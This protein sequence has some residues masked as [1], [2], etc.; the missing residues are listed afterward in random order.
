M[1][2][3][4]YCSKSSKPHHKE[5][6]IKTSGLYKNIEV[7]EIINNG[8]SLTSCYNRGYLKSKYDIVVFC[9]DDILIETK[10][11][12][13]KLIKHFEKN[14]EYGIIGVAGSKYLPESG[15][16][17][18]MPKRMYGRVKHTHN[19][20]S[21]LSEYSPDLGKGIENVINV[22]GLFF[23]IHKQRIY[24]DNIYK[25]F[26]ETV[27]GFHF[28]D[29]DFCFKNFISGVKIG[30]ITN[31]RINH[32]SIGQTNEEWEEN[33]KLFVAKN[34][35]LLPK[36]VSDDFIN[37]KLKILIGCISFQGLT[38]SE[39]STMELAKGLSK[40]GCDVY[41]VSNIGKSFKIEAE[42]NNIKVFSI[43]EPPGYKLGDGKWFLNTPNGPVLS[44]KGG[45]YRIKDY[46]FD[47]IH[48]NHTPITKKLLELYPNNNFVNIV[49][50][51][52]IDLENPIK[53]EKIKKYIAIRPSI[54]KHLIDNFKI[55]EEKITTIYNLFNKSRFKPKNKKNSNK[56]IT[57]FVGTM[58]YLRKNVIL[59][60][61]KTVDELWLVGKDSMGYASEFNDIYEN[62][63][64]F[65]PTDKIEEYVNKCDETAG[66]FLGRSTIEGYLCNKPGWIYSVDKEGN[67]IDKKY[68][69]VPKDMSLFDNDK[70]IEQYKKVY[71]DT[72]NE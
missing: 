23:T 20:K 11:W 32:M 25:P 6:I 68:T 49:R 27:K 26:D 52:V 47:V 67:I 45:L 7:I 65:P 50:S 4:V 66:I 17:W 12:G 29:V 59:D 46:N 56:K 33:R 10:Q 38:G 51:E 15:K 5:H 28:Y 62:I 48:C 41:V 30:V 43:D 35:N 58:D 8:E 40:K 57:L 64:Y 69:E 22:D 1:I 2:S 3:V 19:N 53:D 63:T 24:N 70:I 44:K 37:R 9:H 14:S 39:I 16:W 42:K 72:F 21:W 36:K 18:E 71:I 13:K 55:K 54:K 60:L 61:Q 31:I 34:K